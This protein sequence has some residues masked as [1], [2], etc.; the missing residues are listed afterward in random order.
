MEKRS[1]NSSVYL[2]RGSQLLLIDRAIEKVKE[3]FFLNISDLNSYTY[4]ANSSTVD[5]IVENANTFSIFDEKKLVLVKNC[6]QFSNNEM[7]TLETYIN[8]PNKNV[9]LILVSNDTKK[10]NFKKGKNITIQNF[11]SIDEFPKKILEEAKRF[12]IKLTHKAANELYKMLGEDLKTINHELHKILQFFGTEKSITD[13]DINSFITRRDFDD[14]FELVNSISI[15]NKK[16]AIK[17]L[18]DLENQNYDH[19]SILNTLVWRFKQ[20]LHVKQLES[21]N[22]K[23]DEIAKNIAVSRGALYY[24]LKQS[25]NFSEKQLSKIILKLS[26]LD[27]KFKSTYQENYNHLTKFI[28]DICK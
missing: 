22:L 14:I 18:S 20:M 5:E 10:P 27:F 17:V 26:R 15:K 21:R 9:C 16:N 24:L 3:D 23:N 6:D 4:D 25:K 12:N 11:D 13:E 19:L 8:S 7:K 1:S 28:L 2:F